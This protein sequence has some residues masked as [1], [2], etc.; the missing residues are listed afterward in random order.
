LGHGCRLFCQ[1][2]GHPFVEVVPTLVKPF[3]TV[4]WLPINILPFG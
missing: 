2:L 3:P 4:S 1:L